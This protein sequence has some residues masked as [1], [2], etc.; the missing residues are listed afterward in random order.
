LKTSLRFF[1]GLIFF[2]TAS[3]Y[4]V[5]QNTSG[6][7]RGV[8]KSNDD[9]LLPFATIFVKQNGSGTTTNEKGVYEIELAPG[10]YDLVF[11]F[12]GYETTLRKVEITNGFIQLDVIM[13]PQPTILPEFVTGGNAEDPAYTI[14]RKAIA[15][16]NYHR[17]ELDWYSARVYIKGVGKLKDYPWLAK[18]AVEKEGIKKNQ[19]FVS[20]SVSDIKYTRPNKFEE[21]VIS[22]RSDGKDNNTSP[23]QFVFGSFYEPM[24]AET[25]S[26]LS[27]KAFS[28]YKFEYLGTFK[29]RE[30]DVS[31]IKVTPRSK[32][33]DVVD[34]EILI[35]E[36]W[37]S[38]HS[39]D[40][41]TTKLGIDIWVKMMS[42][43][44][45]DKVWLPVSHR[46][47]VDGKFFGFEFEYNY[48]A[49]VS[50]Y[51][52]QVNPKVYVETKQMEVVDEK[53]EKEEAKEIEKKYAT[54][55]SSKQKAQIDKTKELQER[56]SSGKEIT[57]K[58]L[59]TLMKEYEKE[60]IKKSK[61]PE[62]VSNTSF[63]IDSGAY[64]KDSVY[65]THVRP[66]PLTIDEVV[67]Y[68]KMDSIAEVKRKEEAGDT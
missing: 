34:G 51:K 59:N 19:A 25:V 67:G 40:L 36:N 29:D 65:W 16:A 5:A 10:W 3:A 62:V 64:K 18:K 8:V 17:N 50:N 47:K 41:H 53:I 4:A 44:V 22:I 33:D 15:K 48:L 35:V 26:P 52:I 63:K 1:L 20:E 2:V 57:R 7:V 66:V 14:M 11:Q 27:P 31:R 54:A 23:N 32:G 68:K 49:T 61:E 45:E 60:E 55:K 12:L 38:I 21:K 13:K 46:F 58:E 24:I 37:W 56:L 28:Y 6:G 30:Y 39:V 42:A 9:G 43:P